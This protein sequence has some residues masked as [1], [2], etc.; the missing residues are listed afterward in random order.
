M[1]NKYCGFFLKKKLTIL[2]F[3]TYKNYSF[4]IP[5][6]SKPTSNISN[7]RIGLAGLQSSNGMACAQ[8]FGLASFIE[9]PGTY[10]MKFDAISA[11]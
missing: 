4:A 2:Y 1:I 7:I 11:F 9:V 8:R 6:L 3:F 10:Y 5:H